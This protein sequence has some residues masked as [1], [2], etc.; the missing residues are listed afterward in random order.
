MLSWEG[1]LEPGSFCN[2]PM[3]GWIYQFQSQLKRWIEA[4]DFYGDRNSQTQQP[5]T[6]ALV[7]ASTCQYC[8]AGSTSL[9]PTLHQGHRC[10][11][12]GRPE[13]QSSVGI[14]YLPSKTYQPLHA[15]CTSTLTPWATNQSSEQLGAPYSH[16]TVMVRLRSGVRCA[17]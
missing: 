12:E 11:G 8:T 1:Q 10:P 6:P 7:V 4:S 15:H 13:G 3:P 5:P 16:T 9:V 14:A 17:S 2:S